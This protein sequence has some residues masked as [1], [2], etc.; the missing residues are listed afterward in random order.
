MIPFA[1]LFFPKQL[2]THNKQ[3]NSLTITVTTTL[4]L[5][6]AIFTPCHPFPAGHRFFFQAMLELDKKIRCVKIIISHF[7]SKHSASCFYVY[8]CGKINLRERTLYSLKLA[9][10]RWELCVATDKLWKRTSVVRVN[11]L[12]GWYTPLGIFLALCPYNMQ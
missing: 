6:L 12:G 5:S 1:S 4:L 2:H 7:V 10:A 3:L 9:F 8:F 11:M